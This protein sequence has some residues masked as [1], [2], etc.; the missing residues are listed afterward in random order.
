MLI[1]LWLP[2]MLLLPLDFDCS[3]EGDPGVALADAT[4]GLT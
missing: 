2:A 1:P 4:P 3:S